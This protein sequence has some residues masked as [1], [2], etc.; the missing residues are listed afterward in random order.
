MNTLST[1]SCIQARIFHL[2]NRPPFMT[3]GDLAEV[4]MT[5]SKRIGEQVKRNPARFPEDF[6]FYL[7]E[8]EEHMWSQTA[9]TS[10]K[11]RDD[12]RL[13][14]FTH[15]GANALSGVLRTPVATEISVAIHRA[16]AAMEQKALGDV[17]FI[18]NKLQSEAGRSKPTR[19]QL[20]DGIRA[21]YSF[22]T[23]ARMGNASKPKL[24]LV[25]HECLALG[26][27]VALPEGTP[28]LIPVKRA[29]Q[30]DMFNHG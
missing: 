23:I 25:A 14:V 16:F 17:T 9:T 24:A 20:L 6:A 30:T 10:A 7:T 29:A 19:V 21:G 2:P 13:L 18:L 22:K 15:A 26:L 8:A 4:Y 27:I 28:A 3:A 11:K 5:V 12:M 1:I